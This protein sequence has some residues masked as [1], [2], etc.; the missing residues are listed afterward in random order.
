MPEKDELSNLNPAITQS[1]FKWLMYEKVFIV[2]GDVTQGRRTKLVSS[3]FYLEEMPH[4]RGYQENRLLLLAA[5]KYFRG[6]AKKTQLPA[7]AFA[8]ETPDD[9]GER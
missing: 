4:G 2:S 3:C 7:H 6:P 8:S 9:N 5:M 1:I